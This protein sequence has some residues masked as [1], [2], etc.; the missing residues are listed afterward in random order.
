MTAFLDTNVLVYGFDDREPAK[1]AISEGIV[2]AGAQA[3]DLV[4]STQV[5]QEFY[6]TVSRKFVP[7]LEP[8]I[9]DQAL[10]DFTRFHVVQVD[11]PIIFSTIARVRSASISFWDA[12]IVEAALVAGA[13]RLL[14]ED[15]QDG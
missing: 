2:K 12:L 4:I 9:V 3:G 1:Q 10:R 15:L 6:W 13:T 7:R 8:E 11:V 5:L 14:T